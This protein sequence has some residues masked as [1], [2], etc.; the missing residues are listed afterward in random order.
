MG[1]GLSE[2][3][4]IFLAVIG[5]LALV[6]AAAMVAPALGVAVF[7]LFALFGGVVVIYTANAKAA[8]ALATT[9]SNPALRTAA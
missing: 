3:A 9:S 7:G 1:A 4:G 6:G 2:L 8:A 5:V